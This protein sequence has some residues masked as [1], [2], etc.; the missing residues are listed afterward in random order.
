MTGEAATDPMLGYT[1]ETEVKVDQD[2]PAETGM[3]AETD[4]QDIDTRLTATEPRVVHPTDSDRAITDRQL[5]TPDTTLGADHPHAT[6]INHIDVARPYKTI[7]Q[8]M[9]IKIMTT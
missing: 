4:T 7:P 9:M 3:P 6:R 2:T 5:R 1:Q 8:I